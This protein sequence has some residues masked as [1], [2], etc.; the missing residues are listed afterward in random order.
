MRMNMLR[1]ICWRRALRQRTSWSQSERP[2][3]P[4]SWGCS[5][6]RWLY[7]S[8]TAGHGGR[9]SSLKGTMMSSNLLMTHSTL[10]MT[11]LSRSMRS[12][13]LRYI[14]RYQHKAYI[15]FKQFFIYHSLCILWDLS[16]YLNF[17]IGI[18]VTAYNW[19]LYLG[20]PFNL[21]DTNR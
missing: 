7:G 16:N 18:M 15:F 10:I 19:F 12:S 20:F 11:L 6:D 8:R 21:K 3:W 9:Q 13:N 2:S 1:C 14:Y 17:H 4:R 5:Q